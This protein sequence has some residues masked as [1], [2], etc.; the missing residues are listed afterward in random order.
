M[1]K[2][3]WEENYENVVKILQNVEKRTIKSIN[4]KRLRQWLSLQITI[5]RNGIKDKSGY[6]YKHYKLNYEKAKKIEK[7]N[8]TGI[9]KTWE[10]NFEHYKRIIE[11]NNE[12]EKTELDSS[13]V[14][15]VVFNR[16][17]FNN[18]IRLE[19]GSYLY[20]DRLNKHS[21]SK[22]QIDK[23][24]EIGF[25]WSKRTTF[26]EKLEK[27]IEFKSLYNREPTKGEIYEKIDLYSFVVN[28]R[29][30]KNNGIKDENGNYLYKNFILTKE[31]IEKLNNVNFIW[32]NKEYKFLKS[33]IDKN[34]KKRKLELLRKRFIMYLDSLEK[35]EFEIKKDINKINDEFYD[36]LGV[37][38]P[39]ETTNSYVLR[40][41][42]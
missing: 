38:T 19:D 41:R 10:E 28:I 34:Y 8:I 6:K 21:L 42:G 30:I 1:K 36:S 15:W 16:T 33:K 17:I 3:T 35:K 18:G 12:G 9:L 27:Y 22:E 37:N 39:F 23:L 13:L 11:K 40:K 14:R 4:D 2:N 26:E 31:N 24:N 25:V 5:I 20:M 29:I 32:D 7:L